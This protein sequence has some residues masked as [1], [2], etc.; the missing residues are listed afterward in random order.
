[1]QLA[2]VEALQAPWEL[3]VVADAEKLVFGS[4]LDEEGERGASGFTCPAQNAGNFGLHGFSGKPGS[5]LDGFRGYL[6]LCISFGQDGGMPSTGTGKEVSRTAE[7][8]GRQLPELVAISK[9]DAL[10]GAGGF[11]AVELVTFFVNVGL[12][13]RLFA[14]EVEGARP[15]VAPIA[16][17]V[18]AWATA[19]VI[20]RARHVIG[21][22]ALHTAAD[23]VEEIQSQIDAGNVGLGGINQRGETVSEARKGKGTGRAVEVDVEGFGL[24]FLAGA[25]AA[26]EVANPADFVIIAND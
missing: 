20:H 1:M 11:G 22:D 26:C 13:A 21:A 18:A 12:F 14:A 24:S 8:V 19:P 10:P 15:P 23:T 17:E 16:D 2:R 6:K 7:N 4:V 5:C 9:L 3:F 25:V